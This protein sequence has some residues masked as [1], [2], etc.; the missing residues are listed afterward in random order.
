MHAVENRDAYFV[1]KRNAAYKLRLSCLQKVTTTFHTLCNGV[2]ADTTDEYICIRES[3]AIKSMRRLV[4]S[5][6]ELFEDEYLRVP[7]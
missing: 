7:N 5:V 4:I 3:I 6:I 2:A 1:Q